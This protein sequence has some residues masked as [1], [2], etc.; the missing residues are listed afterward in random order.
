LAERPKK[1]HPIT[2]RPRESQTI[3][4]IAGLYFRYKRASQPVFENFHLEVVPGERLGVFAPSEAGKSTLALCLNGLIPRMI[5]GE[6]RG[7]IEVDGCLTHQSWPRELASRVGVLFQDFEAQLFSTRVD[8]EVA[9]GPENFG[10]ARPEL[11]RRVD[12]ALGLVG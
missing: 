11:C 9:F 3:V 10:F 7:R 12:R 2:A 6:F 4:K 5:K 1:W 8:Q